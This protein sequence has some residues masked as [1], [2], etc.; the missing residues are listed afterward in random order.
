MNPLATGGGHH[1][2]SSPAVV[3]GLGAWSVLTLLA[4]A[5]GETRVGYGMAIGGL[6]VSTGVAAVRAAQPRQA[7]AGG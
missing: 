4:F 1:H 5:V 7:T 3:I 2:S 6:V